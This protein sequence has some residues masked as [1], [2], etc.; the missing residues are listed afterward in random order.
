MYY[1]CFQHI[2]T[3]VPIPSPVSIKKVRGRGNCKNEI[4]SPISVLKTRTVE[5]RM[6]NKLDCQ[7]SLDFFHLLPTDQ[8]DASAISNSGKFAEFD[9]TNPSFIDWYECNLKNNNA[10]C[11]DIS[12]AVINFTTISDKLIDFVEN[13]FP[14]RVASLKFVYDGN[15]TQ[16]ISEDFVTKLLTKVSSKVKKTIFM[17]NIDLS[18]SQLQQVFNLLY[19]LDVLRFDL[20]KLDTTNLTLPNLQYRIKVLDFGKV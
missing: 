12:I 6:I 19:R 5:D 13:S 4:N 11:E 16:Q 17:P 7:A 15:N 18:S 2:H 9:F 20:C 3:F 1:I 10:K 8:A 14:D